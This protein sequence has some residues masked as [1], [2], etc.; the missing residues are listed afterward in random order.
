MTKA[1]REA[2]MKEKLQRYP[3]V[4]RM[5]GG[6]VSTRLCAGASCVSRSPQVTGRGL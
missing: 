1:F 6:A 3:K 2:Q 4:P 5:G